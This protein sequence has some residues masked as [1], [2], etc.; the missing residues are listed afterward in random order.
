M[1]RSRFGRSGSWA[2][3][4][5]L[6]IGITPGSQSQVAAQDDGLGLS[7]EDQGGEATP[8]TAEPAPAEPAPEGGAVEGQVEAGGAVEE[9]PVTEEPA[10]PEPTVTAKPAVGE[11]EMLVTGSRI[12]RSAYAQPSAV[13]V[14]DRKQLQLSGANNMADVVKYMNINSGSEF[15]ADV[16]GGSVGTS[17]FNLRG[18]GLNSTL[19]LLNGRR[20]VQS[21][22]LATDGS[23][24]V[25]TNTLPLPMVERIE[26]L[27][28]GAS[29]IYGSDAVAGVVNLITRKNFDGFEAQVGGQSTDKFDQ[30]EWDVSLLGGA[31]SDH[32]R[33]MVMA[34]YLKRQPLLATDREFTLNHKN[35]STLGQPGAYLPLD[36]MFKPTANIFPDP[37]CATGRFSSPT[38]PPPNMPNGMPGAPINRFCT[39]DF[40]SYYMLVLDEQRVN[41][42][43][44]LEHDISDHTMV[45]LE[46]GYARNDTHRILSPSF[47]ILQTTL[48]PPTNQYNPQ[49]QTLKYYGRLLGGNAPPLNQTYESNTLHT[50]AGIS[51]DFGGLSDSKFGE[52]EWEISG[53]YGT[54]RY[55]TSL[56]DQL[57]GPLQ[58]AI[59]SC[60]PMTDPA[61]CLNVFAGGA[62]NSQAILDRVTGQLTVNGFTELT[63]G[64]GDMHGPIAKL[65]G[66]DLALAIGVQVRREVAGTTGDHDSTQF[67]Y[68][69]LLGGEDFVAERKIYAGY[70]ELS[71]PFY[72]GFETQIAGRLENFS[73]FGSTFNPMLGLSWIPAKTFVGDEASQAS[74]VRLRGTYANSFVA[75]SLLQGYGSQTALLQV[76]N[77]MPMMPATVGTF[78][79]VRTIGNPNL[80]PQTS[81]A[82]TAGIEWVPVKGLM[83]QADYWHYDYKDIIVKEDPQGLA[84]ADAAA[85]VP[86]SPPG[87]PAVHR[88][89][90]KAI[91]G[92]DTKFIN[93]TSVVT[94]GIDAELMY[95]TDFG[96]TAGVF[97]FGASGS[98]VLSYDIPAA[99]FSA[100]SRNFP[101]ANCSGKTCDVAGLR[102]ATNFARPIPRLRMTIP[103]AW[104]LF[105]H[106]AAVIGHLIGGYKDDGPQTPPIMSFPDVDMFFSID[107]QYAYRIDEGDGQATTIKIGVQNIANAYPP[108]LNAPLGYDT[109]THDP[110]G[111]MLYAR[112][113]QE[114]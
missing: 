19:V 27:K 42:Y 59:N 35:V 105:G 44:T 56:A 104:S 55:K 57:K 20:L 107:L 71:V 21:A 109:L 10:E 3:V 108:T 13:Q 91:T 94:H 47:P 34:S 52:W 54:N 103:L 9:V 23:N 72:R 46:T 26:V 37:N 81:T 33:A 84:D 16:S 60:N 67:N 65:P 30:H 75:P 79:P 43:G 93:A 106:T 28:G 114:L 38:P 40:N 17:Q 24:F 41:T 58:T 8:D 64:G 5:L 53:T 100:V 31:H 7:P 102:N 76:F 92:I 73:D 45:F 90:A 25:D 111:R 18:L 6:L 66:G 110:R 89:A 74:K 14:M 22:A 101:D 87:S 4:L 82:I 11:D 69:F 77:N 99:Q 48:I 36:A 85:A 113:I 80:D 63:T 88:D 1:H 29:A 51:G 39:F 112:L 96:A 50:V 86:G 78:V 98:Y 12:K 49:G 70:G 83:L 15:N 32:S 62:P 68:N 61:N 97:S 95:R 2:A